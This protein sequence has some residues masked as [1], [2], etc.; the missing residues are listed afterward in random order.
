VA[1]DVIDRCGPSFPERLMAGANCDVSEF[2]TGYEAA[3]AV[4]ELGALW[5]AVSA[6]DGKA[7][8][9]GQMA[10]YRRL[11]SA[12]R[13]TTFWLAR[14]AA[15][16]SFDVEALVA[17]YGGGFKSL[18]ALAVEVASPVEREAIQRRAAKLVEAGAPE[19]LAREVATAQAVSTAADL[20][21]LADASGWPL[22]S[23]ARV[24]HA[25]GEAFGFDRLRSA[26]AGDAVGDSFERTALRRLLEEMLAE[27]AGL[28][29]EVIAGG[30]P[31]AAAEPEGARAAVDAWIAPRRDQAAVARR[32]LEEIE[33]STGPWTFAKLTIANAA[34]RELTQ[35]EGAKRKRK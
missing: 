15:R 7:P 29:R 1:N 13:G 24:Y 8:A 16:G 10:L 19:D 5:D 34:L 4:L 31:R 25:V 30:H 17:R 14:R 2:A 27:Q 23:A 33:A 21:D 9:A 11:S 18:R 35:A 28:A 22:K 3:K 6:L 12:L 32:T 20:V 26:A